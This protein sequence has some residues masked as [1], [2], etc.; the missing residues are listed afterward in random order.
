MQNVMRKLEEIYHPLYLNAENGWYD[1]LLK[2][3]EDSK[4]YKLLYEIGIRVPRRCVFQ[5]KFKL[6]WTPCKINPFF[7]HFMILNTWA[8]GERE[9]Q[10][11]QE[12]LNKIKHG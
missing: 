6:D 10:K 12:I 9:D 11:L 2:L 7:H 4:L 1:F 5:V 8:L 3:D